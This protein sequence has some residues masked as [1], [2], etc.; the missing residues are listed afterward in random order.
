MLLEEALGGLRAGSGFLP[1]RLL[2]SPPRFLAPARFLTATN[3]RLR[4]DSTVARRQ[5]DF[6]SDDLVPLRVAAFTLGNGKKFAQPAPRVL[7]LR[8][9]ERGFAWLFRN[10]FFVV[11]DDIILRTAPDGH[12]K[13]KP[14]GALR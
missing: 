10:G 6:E 11:H 2:G 8:F 7:G 12:T 14:Q 1:P 3:I 4:Q 5:L 9:R 13:P